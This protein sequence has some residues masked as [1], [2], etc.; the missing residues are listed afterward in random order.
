MMAVLSV[1]ELRSLL[2]RRSYIENFPKLGDPIPGA[3]SLLLENRASEV[4]RQLLRADLPRNRVQAK[5]KGNIVEVPFPD[6]S[7]PSPAKLQAYSRADT[8]VHHLIQSMKSVAESRYY[9]ATLGRQPSQGF[10]ATKQV[11]SKAALTSE[12]CRKQ[13][14]RNRARAEPKSSLQLY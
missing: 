3:R 10:A 14:H 6:L 7:G 4:R 1:D 13:T 9:P 5:S 12:I 11:C 8:L 2:V